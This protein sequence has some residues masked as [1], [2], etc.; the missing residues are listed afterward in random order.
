ML[1]VACDR[2]GVEFCD[3]FI[4]VSALLRDDVGDL[5]QHTSYVGT[6]GDPLTELW[7]VGEGAPYLRTPDLLSQ[8]ERLP[9]QVGPRREEHNAVGVK[10]R[11]ARQD[12]L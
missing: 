7:L 8:L 3:V 4:G 2:R 10:N 12:Q 6:A 9:R 5:S 11:A 1:Y